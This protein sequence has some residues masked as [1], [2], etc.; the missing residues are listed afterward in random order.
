AEC[1]DM[2]ATW[3]KSLSRPI[4][5]PGKVIVILLVPSL[6]T[7]ICPGDERKA[8]PVGECRFGSIKELLVN[9]T[10]SVVN[11]VPSENFSPGRR[12]NVTL[13]LSFETFQDVASSGSSC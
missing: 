12:A 7:L 5:G 9:A 3:S 1:A 6:F 4:T 13:R 8:S 11:G 10:S 2:I